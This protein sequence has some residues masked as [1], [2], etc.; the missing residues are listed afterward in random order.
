MM[1][2]T[3]PLVPS[4]FA[5]RS[6]HSILMQSGLQESAPYW[7]ACGLVS[8][9]GNAWAILGIS[10]RAE[11]HKALDLL[12][13]FLGGTHVLTVAVP[14]ALFSAVHL[15]D[16]GGQN[17]NSQAYH[18]TG[19]PQ[20]WNET[21]CKAF[22]STFYCLS[23]ATCFTVSSISYHRLWM[24]KWPV[25]YRLS[26]SRK[27]AW[28]SAAGGWAAA[29]VLATLPSLGWHSP[30]QRF[31]QDGTCRFTPGHIGLGFGLCLP[32]LVGG[33]TATALFCCSLTL[34]ETFCKGRLIRKADQLER[35]PKGGQEE[36]PAIV[37]EDVRGQRRSSI[38]GSEPRKTSRETT[39]LVTAIVLLYTGF[40][41]VPLLVLSCVSVQS[42]STPACGEVLLLWS[43]LLQTLPLPILV[44]GSERY[45]PKARPV[46]DR[47]LRALAQDETT[48][49]DSAR[50]DLDSIA[51]VTGSADVKRATLFAS[52]RGAGKPFLNS[53]I[54]LAQK[55]V[56]YLQYARTLLSMVPANRR[57]SHDDKDFWGHGPPSS[58][59]PRWSSSDDICNS[60]YRNPAGGGLL[61]LHN[62]LELLPPADSPRKQTNVSSSCFSRQEVTRF[63]DDDFPATPRHYCPSG[64][65]GRRASLA[66]IGGSRTDY[67]IGPQ[68]Q[69]PTA[70]TRDGLAR[71]YY[72]S[73]RRASVSGPLQNQRTQSQTCR[74]GLPRIQVTT[75]STLSVQEQE[76][77]DI[78]ST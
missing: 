47:C 4:S 50:D 33:G 14:L 46:W 18:T 52:E 3:A 19:N 75:A 34:L 38:D 12:F 22:V 20:K 36:V 53:P 61:S 45:R 72:P 32:L 58:M 57:H 5:S 67:T 51:V 71:S 10:A 7:I 24:V 9:L 70:L 11:Q 78:N 44:W 1:R 15:G 63:I 74:T 66:I 43:S 25:N 48:D 8:I 16:G 77:P 28:H 2:S 49:N 27:Q 23:L 30:G 37:V 60:R 54:P 41:G 6:P 65:R 13:V 29:F 62:F 68:T 26:R 59:L 21:L 55:R 56:Q 64:D 17:Q 40:T 76:K 35:V 31:Y 39:G 69:H 42:Y 73:G